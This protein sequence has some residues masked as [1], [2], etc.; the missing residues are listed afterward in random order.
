MKKET[1]L[2]SIIIIVFI[3][4]GILYINNKDKDVQPLLNEVQNIQSITEDNLNIIEPEFKKEEIEQEKEEIESKKEEIEQEKESN[5]V[6]YICGAVKKP[7]VYTLPAGSR[8]NDVINMAGGAL[9]EADLNQLNLAEKIFDSQKI[10]VPKKGEE[11]DKSILKVENKEEDNYSIKKSNNQLIN[12]NTDSSE[13]LQTLPGIGSVIAQN[14]I[15]Y[16]NSQ[17]PFSSIEEIKNVPRIGE[18]TFEKI[19]DKITVD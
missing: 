2:Y 3:I 7:N 11:I 16:R 19:K 13:K 18:K 6:V 4:S 12:I 14:I 10:Y 17:G 8:I 9:E 5:C 15:D 1:L